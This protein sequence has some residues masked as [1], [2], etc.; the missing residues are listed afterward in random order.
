[1]ENCPSFT[2]ACSSLSLSQARATSHSTRSS[3]RRAEIRDGERERKRAE[4][5]KRGTKLE[6]SGVVTQASLGRRRAVTAPSLRCV[7]AAFL[8]SLNDRLL[9][10]VGGY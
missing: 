9:R 8:V 1:M 3:A 5:E 10:S 7:N 6:E 2:W 4:K